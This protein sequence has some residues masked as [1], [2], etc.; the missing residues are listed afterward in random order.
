M[1][2]YNCILAIKSKK[3]N[4]NFFSNKKLNQMIVLI[5]LKDKTYKF[6]SK[7]DIL[8]C[9]LLKQYIY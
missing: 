9:T 2:V 6:T 3:N 7:N 5:P 4:Y 1:I 8:I